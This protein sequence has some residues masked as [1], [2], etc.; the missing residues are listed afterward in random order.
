MG[1]GT[2]DASGMVMT[3][4]LHSAQPRTQSGINGTTISSKPRLGTWLV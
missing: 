4:V 2:K 3:E 1:A